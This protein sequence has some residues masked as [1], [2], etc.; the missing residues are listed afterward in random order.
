M[1]LGLPELAGYLAVN[2][3]AVRL[4]VRDSGLPAFGFV[5]SRLNETL[6]FLPGILA[7]F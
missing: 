4:D 3:L 5:A 7:G 1:L 6:S 2:R